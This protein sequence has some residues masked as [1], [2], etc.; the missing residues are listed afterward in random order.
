[1]PAVDVELLL[2]PQ[3][4]NAAAARSVLAACLHRLNLDLPVRERVG[5]YPSPTILVDGVDVMTG[6]PGVAP[7]Q[8]CRLDLPTRQRVLR[9]LRPPA[10]DGA[11]STRHP[12]PGRRCRPAP[13]TSD[14]HEPTQTDGTGHM[15]ITVRRDQHQ[16]RIVVVLSGAIDAAAVPALRRALVQA[17]RTREPILIDLSTATSIHRDPLTTLVAAYRQAQR[18]HTQLLLRTGPTQLRAVLAAFKIPPHNPRR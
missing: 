8:A 4:P 15:P 9:A 12:A 14:Y 5:D 10:A 1:M 18:N 16:P 2:T 7:G 3:C 6:Q 17:L 11:G 13:A